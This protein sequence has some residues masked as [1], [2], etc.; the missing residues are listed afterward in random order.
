MLEL[1]QLRA[2]VAVA[3][4]LHF[5]RAASRLRL[6]QSALSR[7]VQGMEAV[8]GVTLLERTQRKV[9]LT[10][11]GAL[12]LDRARQILQASAEAERDT[13]RASRGE[14]GQLTIGFVHSATYGLLPDLLRRFRT[15]FPD[16]EL[17]LREMRTPDQLAALAG[18]SIDIG[19]VRPFVLPAGVEAIPIVTERFVIALP[20]SH[21]LARCRELALN[22]LAEEKF[23]MFSGLD[24][25]MFH[26][27]AIAMCERAGF[28]PRVAQEAVHVHT[29]LG[30]VGSGFGIAVV[31]EIARRLATP[32]IVFAEII[33]DPP[34]IQVLLAFRGTSPKPAATAFRNV[35]ATYIAE[36]A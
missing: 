11:P 9:V 18:E 5:G 34:P 2:F 25:P 20:A 3:E 26:S 22:T 21:P 24:S 8:L 16:V 7:Q 35:M 14:L 12:L 31:P 23:V 32:N 10:A 27:A 28:H 17:R 36:H 29:V 33:D 1:R 13:R 15:L 30:L 4:E 6:A 19:L